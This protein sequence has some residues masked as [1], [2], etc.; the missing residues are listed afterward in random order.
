MLV[1][2]FGARWGVLGPLAIYLTSAI[3]MP[4]FMWWAASLNQIPL[5]IAFFIAVAAWVRYLR[6][7]GTAWL[8]ITALAVG[9]GFACYVKALMIVPV[10]AVLAVAYFS[11]GP[12]RPR[13]LAA[14]HKY[15][16]AALLGTALV[17]GYVAY[18][19]AAVP[20]PFE[21][22]DST[23]FKTGEV[24][25]A[26]LGTSFATGLLGGPWRW[27]RTSPPIVL[28]S[29]PN[30]SVH[31]AWVLLAL[32]VAFTLLRRRHAGMGWAL[33]AGYT[34][35]AYLLLLSTRGQLYGRLAGLEYRYLTDVVCVLVLCLGLV[36]LELSGAPG[37]SRAR[38][39]PKLRV[40]IPATWV[41]A[42]VVLVSV[43][44]TASSW[45]YIRYWHRDNAG[46]A[47]TNNL[48]NELTSAGVTDLAPQTLPPEVMPEYTQ[49]L[50][51]SKE[52]LELYETEVAFPESARRLTVID[53]NGFLRPAVIEAGL[54]SRPGP[55]TDCG[56]R[57]TETKNEVEI[58]LEGQAFE[59]GWWL[60][61]G[62]L[63]SA[64]S[65][66]VIAAGGKNVPTE[67]HRGLNSLYVYIDGTFSDVSVGGLSPGTT[68]CVDTVEVGR[69]VP[70]AAL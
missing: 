43:A 52:F 66:V 11:A 9:F 48:A 20:A 30:W 4:A 34:V 35:G 57:V 24:A 59:W 38:T 16:L 22:S 5:Q 67:V 65:P 56:W 47:Y 44:G 1:T 40:H 62:Y 60:R 18:Y 26:M 17:I 8:L 68:L 10:L 6:S 63:S 7:T 70:G 19:S 15:W 55:V 29:P 14:L 42:A 21:S 28:A 31:F 36:F 49:P 23:G 13:L 37:S 50:N 33:L 53:G 25:D 3:S 27:W 45:Q 58:P 54:K 64:D 39:N 51:T 46:R 41:I 2:L 69:P 12:I 61:L 32:L